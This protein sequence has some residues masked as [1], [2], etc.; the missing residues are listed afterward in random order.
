MSTKTERRQTVGDI[1]GRYDATASSTLLLLATC[2]ADYQNN[3]L[4][5]A[6]TGHISPHDWATVLDTFGFYHDEYD[7]DFAIHDGLHV[8][9]LT[10]YSR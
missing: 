4:V 9:V 2:A 1:V 6:T 7:Y 8:I 3:R 10:H 5:V